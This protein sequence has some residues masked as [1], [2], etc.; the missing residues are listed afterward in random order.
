MFSHLSEFNSLMSLDNLDSLISGEE[1]KEIIKIEDIEEKKQMISTKS[2]IKKSKKILITPNVDYYKD[3]NVL[4][5]IQNDIKFMKL[6]KYI[7]KPKKPL[8]FMLIENDTIIFIVASSLNY[9]IV[10]AT[11]QV[12]EPFF[13]L[14][15]SVNLCIKFPYESILNFMTNTDKQNGLYTLLLYKNDGGMSLK[16]ISEDKKNIRSTENFTTFDKQHTLTTIFSNIVSGPEFSMFDDDISKE[17]DYILKIK[18]MPI[19][20][21][22]ETVNKGNFSK[23]S[24]EEDTIHEIIIN[25]NTVKISIINRKNKNEIIIA[26]EETDKSLINSVIYWNKEKLNNTK[27]TMIK[28]S[29]IFKGAENLPNSNDII[30][31]AICEWETYTTCSTYMFIKIIVNIN[32]KDVIQSDLTDPI[33]GNIFNNSNH[34]CEYTLCHN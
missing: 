8:V 15:S 20:F 12:I 13:Y 5:G 19:L 34:I 11:F 3:N 6:L 33:Y 16:Y 24:K 29:N 7:A 2:K 31:Y 9:P 18:S 14:N 10:F 17:I 25:D 1:K 26:D 30:Y 21:L 4:M 32:F 23:L 22:T 27:L 28:Y